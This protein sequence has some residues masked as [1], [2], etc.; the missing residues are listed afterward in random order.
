MSALLRVLV[1]SSILLPFG[2]SA[3][4][5]TEEGNRL[6]L[7]GKYDEALR[8]YTEAQ[9][10]APQAAEL[11]YDIG[12]VL[13]RQGDYQG[14]AEAYTRALLMAPPS[15]EQGAAYNLG[16]AR[17]E[18]EEFQEAVKRNDGIGFFE[19]SGNESA[20]FWNAIF[21]SES[22]P[23]VPLPTKQPNQMALALELSKTLTVTE[24]GMLRRHSADQARS[25]LLAKRFPPKRNAARMRPFPAAS[26]DAKVS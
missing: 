20:N 9:V 13:Y 2:G 25:G 19:S 15:L 12:N 1:A 11:Y 18:L 3:H 6:Y 14:A 10:Q 21:S 23:Y 24:N 16:N 5:R 22:D 26:I 7:E 17:Y 8:S 4:R